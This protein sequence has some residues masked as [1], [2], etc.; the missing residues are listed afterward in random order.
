MHQNSCHDQLL[1]Q[2]CCA[3]QKKF[4]KSVSAQITSKCCEDGVSQP[5]K[6]NGKFSVYFLSL[7]LC[8]C[9][10]SGWRVIWRCTF[11]HGR[12]N[13]PK[14]WRS[15]CCTSHAWLSTLIVQ[16]TETFLYNALP[17]NFGVQFFWQDSSPGSSLSASHFSMAIWN[18]WKQK[19]SHQG[20]THKS[21]N[22]TKRYDWSAG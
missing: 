19:S 17:G 13:S 14:N 21:G 8:W 22:W 4:V 10:V 18:D 20:V 11:R 15:K 9:D 6:I 12:Q 16:C 5:I 3:L 2:R 1:R 7:S